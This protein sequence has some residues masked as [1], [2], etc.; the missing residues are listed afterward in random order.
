MSSI[1]E[2]IF[3]RIVSDNFTELANKD[4]EEVHMPIREMFWVAQKA[5]DIFHEELL[6]EAQI[7]TEDSIFRMDEPM[8]IDDDFSPTTKVRKIVGSE[9]YPNDFAK[10]FIPSIH[11]QLDQGRILS[12]KQIETLDKIFDQWRKL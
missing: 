12:E 8:H 9:R 10:K 7:R 6:D 2:S 5:E 11:S 3:V 1:K 4:S